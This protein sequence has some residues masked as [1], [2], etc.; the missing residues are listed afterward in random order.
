MAVHHFWGGGPPPII[1]T[2]NKLVERAGEKTYYVS[3]QGSQRNARRHSCQQWR[4]PQH[5]DSLL[6]G[7]GGTRMMRPRD[8]R[9][10]VDRCLI[11]A[12]M[13]LCSYVTKR[14]QAAVCGRAVVVRGA[15]RLIERSS[16]QQPSTGQKPSA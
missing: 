1:L 2:M 12:T 8:R 5:H 14:R 9:L 10:V 13:I 16:R 4:A 6:R 3:R 15:L 7:R 11:A